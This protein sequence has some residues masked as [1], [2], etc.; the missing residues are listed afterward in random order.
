MK[1]TS[2]I[3]CVIW[4]DFLKQKV[5]SSNNSH[6]YFVTKTWMKIHQGTVS[7]KVSTCT[8]LE[9]V[10][11]LFIN[12]KEALMVFSCSQALSAAEGYCP[13]SQ[14]QLKQLLY[15]QREHSLRIVSFSLSIWVFKY[16]LRT[17]TFKN[18]VCDKGKIVLR[19]VAIWNTKVSCK[20][21]K[22][23]KKR[24]KELRN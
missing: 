4:C 1:Y 2:I 21:G 16:L 10:A 17:V 18:K 9:R 15:Q 20:Q 11:Y 22:V 6:M 13:P 12:K 3:L 23:A 5:N 19:K 8:R 7:A 24:G 14:C